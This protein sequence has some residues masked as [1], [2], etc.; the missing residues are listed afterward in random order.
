MGLNQAIKRLLA[1]SKYLMHFASPLSHAFA[2]A[3]VIYAVRGFCICSPAELIM[4]LKRTLARVPDEKPHKKWVIYFSPGCGNFFTLTLHG[5]FYGVFSLCPCRDTVRLAIRKL[6][7]A[8]EVSK[9]QPFIE[10]SKDFVMSPAKL[11]LEVTLDKEV[12]QFS[13]NILN[14]K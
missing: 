12:R 14:N 2:F 1:Y 4:S 7:Y 13:N 3:R 6:Y 9:E 8:P 5:Y 11:H 10:T